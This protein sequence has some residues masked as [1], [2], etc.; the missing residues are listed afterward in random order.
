MLYVWAYCGGVKRVVWTAHVA[1]TWILAVGFR[2]GGTGVQLG[3]RIQV[4]VIYMVGKFILLVVAAILS[5][6]RNNEEQIE[7]RRRVVLLV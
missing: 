2:V 6:R 1:M 4:L 5:P 7:D 3:G